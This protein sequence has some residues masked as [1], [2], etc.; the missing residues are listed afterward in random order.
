MAAPACTKFRVRFRPVSSCL[1]P[2]FRM[3]RVKV[4]V[5]EVSDE[6]ELLNAAETRPSTN[7]RLTAGGMN[8]APS[9]PV[10]QA[11][12]GKRSSGLAMCIPFA[13]A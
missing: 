12:V 2:A 6:P 11:I 10:P 9:A 7:S 1:F 8:G 4:V 13:A 3:S 5:M